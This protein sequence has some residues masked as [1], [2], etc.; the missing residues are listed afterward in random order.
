MV[1]GLLCLLWVHVYKYFKNIVLALLA[2]YRLLRNPLPVYFFEV[3][4]KL[5]AVH[6]FGNFVNSLIILCDG[7]DYQVAFRHLAIN[8][9]YLL[10]H[11]LIVFIEAGDLNKCFFYLTFF[12]NESCSALLV[13]SSI[14]VLLPNTFALILR[15]L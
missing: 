11:H 14:L 7:I 8:Q 9:S 12:L 13:L 5:S 15:S 3:V 10:N 6:F 1:L 2:G 4:N